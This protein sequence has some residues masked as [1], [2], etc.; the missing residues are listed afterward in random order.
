[1][2]AA[3]VWT[4]MHDAPEHPLKPLAGFRLGAGVIDET[5]NAAHVR[6]KVLA[7]IMPSAT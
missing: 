7:V 3:A 2:A 4:S 1:M 6:G 5:G